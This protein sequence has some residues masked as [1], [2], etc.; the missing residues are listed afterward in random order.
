MTGN[1]GDFPV[2]HVTSVTGIMGSEYDSLSPP[3]KTVIQLPEPS[4]FSIEHQL[5][6]LRVSSTR[7][8][9][10]LC[11]ILGVTSQPRR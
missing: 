10:S 1:S 8:I 7:R 11:L 6:A 3:T 9:F 2:E 5:M 4:W